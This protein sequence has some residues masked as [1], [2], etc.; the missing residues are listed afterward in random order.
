MSAASPGLSFQEQFCHSPASDLRY[1]TSSL[2]P[3]SS[4]VGR[5]LNQMPQIMTNISVLL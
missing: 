2:V 3:V 4:P 1:I 5:G